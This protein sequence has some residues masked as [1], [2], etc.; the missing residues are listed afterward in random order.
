MA[1][2]H[3]RLRFTALT[4][5]V[6]SGNTTRTTSVTRRTGLPEP[7]S[8][9]STLAV[10][11]PKLIRSN[12][13]PTK[14]RAPGAEALLDKLRARGWKT[15]A[16]R[17][18]TAEGGRRRA[19]P[20][21]RGRRVARRRS[22]RGA[23]PG[24]PRLPQALSVRGHVRGDLPVSRLQDRGRAPPGDAGA[25]DAGRRQLPRAAPG[26]PG[27][28]RSGRRPRGA[29]LPAQEPERAGPARGSRGARPRQARR[30]CARRPSRS[31]RRRPRRARRRWRSQALDDDDEE[32]RYRADA[33]PREVPRRVAHRSAAQALPQRLAPRAGRGDRGPRAAAR[34]GPGAATTRSCRCSP[35]PTRRSGSSPRASSRRRSPPASPTPSCAPS[36]RPTGRPRTAR[37]RP[38]GSSAPSS[39]APSSSA[40]TATDPVE[41]A[42]AVSIAVTIRS[43]EAVP[44]C[45][46][47]LSGDDWW[48]R[49][50]AALALAEIRDERALPHLLKMLENPES[51][52]SAAAALG[53]WGTP[54]AL[55][56]LLEAYKQAS[57]QKDLRLEI[58]DAFSRIQDP[59]VAPAAPEDRRRSTPIRSSRT[60]PRGSRRRARAPPVVDR[61]SGGAPS[62]PSTSRPIRSPTLPELLRHARAVGASD[63]HLSTG[64]VPHLRLHGR[65]GPLP[66]PPVSRASR[67]RRGSRRS[68]P[69]DRRRRARRAPPARL[70]PQGPG[71]RPLPH[72]RLLPAQGARRRV[73]PG[74]LRR[75]RTSPTSGCP[76]ASGRSRPTRR[77]SSS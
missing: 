46:R 49:D 63:L 21:G 58:L 55:P 50:R 41:A 61:G 1:D 31:S 57:A 25:R 33:G 2:S 5:F 71:A 45:I 17:D 14:R 27:Q 44:H 20:R 68:S 52:L 30:R 73:P 19:G 11:L 10:R 42:L 32:L 22:R 37:S 60:R 13:W 28:P 12:M 54:K 59:R 3:R 56:G 65:L 43:P 9:F 51:S 62:P 64:T 7:S 8:D 36:A 23:A 39:S 70:L 72:Q 16:E 77:A 15:E 24:G 66:L 74:A 38:C 47:F 34:H 6:T 4:N 29:R 18:E 26:V 67:W 76:R 69:T 75:S 53:V 48:L 40:T 35:T